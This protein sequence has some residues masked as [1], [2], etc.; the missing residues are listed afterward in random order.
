MADGRGDRSDGVHCPAADLTVRALIASNT[1]YEPRLTL[2]ADYTMRRSRAASRCASRP[3]TAAA[4]NASISRALAAGATYMVSPSLGVNAEATSRFETYERTAFLWASSFDAEAAEVSGRSDDGSETTAPRRFLPC[5]PGG[6]RRRPGGAPGSM[7]RVG[8]G[9]PG[10]ACGKRR[11]RKRAH[12]EPRLGSLH[13]RHRVA[14]RI[15]AR[16]D[17]HEQGVP[18]S[19]AG[20]AHYRARQPRLCGRCHPGRRRRLSAQAAQPRP[21]SRQGVR[22]RRSGGGGKAE[23]PSDRAG[24]RRPSRRRGD[25]V[26]RNP[27]C[28]TAFAATTYRC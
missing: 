28:D 14:G 8:R 10:S 21:V 13:L 18:P 25:R 4:T 19:Y 5:P 6:R 9:L 3:R 20:A 1:T 27:R 16:P 23:A 22:A 2:V 7:A 11:R 26:W 12:P 24:D 17:P 15:G